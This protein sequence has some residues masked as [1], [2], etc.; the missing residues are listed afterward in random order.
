MTNDLISRMV[1]NANENEWL[2]HRGRF[3]DV[4]FMLESGKEAWLI[5]ISQGRISH[6]QPGPFVMARWTFALRADPQNWAQFWQPAPPPGFHDLMAMI[7]FKALRTEGDQH[8]FMSNLL[9]FKAMFEG[10]RAQ[11]FAQ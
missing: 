2:V 7:K 1:A 5:T 6:V 10:A 9:Y 11:E 8:I 3:V 4:T